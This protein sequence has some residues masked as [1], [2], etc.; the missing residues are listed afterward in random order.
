M[1]TAIFIY[2]PVPIVGVLTGPDSKLCGLAAPSNLTMNQGLEAHHSSVEVVKWNEQHHKL[3][4][5]DQQGLI[6]VWMM[7]KGIFFSLYAIYILVASIM[8]CV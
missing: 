4:S 3:T 8:K 2:A 1:A 6:V 5:S 7:Y